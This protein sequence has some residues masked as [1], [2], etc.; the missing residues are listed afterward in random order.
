[1]VCLASAARADIT[2]PH[3]AVGLSDCFRSQP[4]Y[5]RLMR[6]V[7]LGRCLELRRSKRPLRLMLVLVLEVD[8]HVRDEA[9]SWGVSL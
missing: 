6:H 9:R 1:M 8:M 7:D 2:V 3:H 4:Y 5:P